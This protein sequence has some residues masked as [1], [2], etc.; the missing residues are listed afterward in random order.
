V[1]LVL[2]D[3]DDREE[4]VSEI[5]DR[6]RPQLAKITGLQVFLRAS[7][8]INLGANQGRA[9]YLY[10]VKALDSKELATWTQQ[11]TAKLRQNPMFT[12]LSNDL[13]WDAN[14]LRL[15]MDRQ[16]AAR[17]GFT[18]ADVDQ[19]LYDA[20]GQRQIS[21]Y[22]TETNQY[23]V[24]LEFTP[25]QRG[26]AESFNYFY[27]RSPLTGEMVPLLAFA[28]VMPAESG[29]VVIAHHGMQPAANISFNLAKGVALGDAVNALNEARSSLQMPAAVHGTFLGAAQA[30]QDSLASQPLLILTALLAV[31]IILGVLYESFIHPLTIL[32]TL[33]SAAIGAIGLLWL[34]GLD[35]SIMALIGI[36][37]LIGIVKKNGILM[38]D[39]AL[40]AQREQGLSAKEAIH[41][42]C[43]VR[44][45]PIMMTT[46]AAMFGAVPLMMGFG[47]GSELRVPL[48]V[49]VVGGLAFSQILTLLTTPVI[50]MQLDRWFLAKTN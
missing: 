15:E 18:A 17:F 46:L 28:K 47:T 39:F 22:Q 16:Q 19:A 26:K 34:W 11:L 9:Q 5:I 31:Y 32:S 7:Q 2:S 24:I 49:A 38:V 42:A 10:V 45:R 30:F 12:D 37:L 33:P 36:I 23:K 27:L 13:Q 35:F 29:P 50:F 43:L 44:F 4:S 3:P 41:Q 14:I 1:W 21:E 6:L 48:G 40:Q 8:D 25:E 20:F